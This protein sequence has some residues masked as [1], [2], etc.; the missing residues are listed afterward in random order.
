MHNG[1]FAFSIQFAVGHQQPEEK[2]QRQNELRHLRDTQS[3]Q[4]YDE[5]GRDAAFNGGTQDFNQFLTKE[6]KQQ[7]KQNRNLCF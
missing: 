4:R 5:S 2:T 1:D 3:E 6:D 7:D